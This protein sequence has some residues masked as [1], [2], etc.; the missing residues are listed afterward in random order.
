MTSTDRIVR[1]VYAEGAGLLASDTHGRVHLLD[2]RLTPVASSPFV[3]EGRPLYGL[4]VAGGWVIGKDRMGAMYRW[5]L[6][7]LDL[8]DRLEPATVCD[9]STLRPRRS[10]PRAAP[11]ASASGATA[12]G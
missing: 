7:T 11:A 4:A 5:S 2:E 3:P 9:R 1:I 8:V 10:P 6:D 12:S